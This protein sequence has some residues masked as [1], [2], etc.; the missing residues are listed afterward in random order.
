M[1]FAEKA[2]AL[3]TK[4][5][6]RD[7]IVL[8]LIQKAIVLASLGKIDEAAKSAKKAVK[9]YDE[10]HCEY[11]K[12]FLMLGRGMIARLAGESDARALLAEGLRTSR[13]MGTREMTW[14]LQR[15]LALYHN[16]RGEPHKAMEYYQDAIDTLKQITE[17]LDDEELRTSYLEVPI[18]LRV[19]NEIKE[20]RARS[21]S[22]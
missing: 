15:E 3:F 5:E 10:I 2:I 11:L 7:D 21:N 1:S 12:P 6:D 20:L 17:T 8:A 4:A 16:D 19:F 13:K 22:S 14:Q 18:R 9:I